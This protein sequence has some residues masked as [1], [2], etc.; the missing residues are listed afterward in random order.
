MLGQ[1]IILLRLFQEVCLFS[2]LKDN[3]L[4]FHGSDFMLN[5]GVDLRKFKV[6]RL[7]GSSDCRLIECNDVDVA[8]SLERC[9]FKGDTPISKSH[10]T[11]KKN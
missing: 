11:D 8:G 4:W 2:E 9:F 1:M 7:L 6:S 5:I 3:K 10:C